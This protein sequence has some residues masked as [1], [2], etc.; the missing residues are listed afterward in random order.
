MRKREREGR[1]S[2]VMPHLDG[3]DPMPTGEAHG[4]FEEVV[5]GCTGSA[6]G[7]AA[8]GCGDIV[9]I[10]EGLDIV[11]LF[12]IGNELE[13]RDHLLGCPLVD[14]SWVVVGPAMVL[15][16]GPCF[17]GIRWRDGDSEGSHGN[18]QAKE[19]GKK[20]VKAEHGWKLA[21]FSAAIYECLGLSFKDV[22][23]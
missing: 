8:A 10:T 7:G 6:V 14:R 22:V 16:Q 5:D 21:R 20:G 17:P 4:P 19:N 13:L 2:V 3:V 1:A 9:G 18:A 15:W 23:Q 11:P 12:E